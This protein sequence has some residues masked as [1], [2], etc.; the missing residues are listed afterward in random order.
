[1]SRSLC[2]AVFT[3]AESRVRA[4]VGGVGP[5]SELRGAGQAPPIRAGPKAG[6]GL[7]LAAGGSLPAPRL[8]LGE[9]LL[10]PMFPAAPRPPGAWPLHTW[11]GCLSVYSFTSEVRRWL[12]AFR[13]LCSSGLVAAGAATPT[14][15][16]SLVLLS[17]RPSCALHGPAT[18]KQAPGVGGDDHLHSASARPPGTERS[19]RGWPWPVR[20]SFRGPSRDR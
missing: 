10:C 13:P 5:G 1:M 15:V 12:L 3:A 9:P 19:R 14:P 17:P 11:S 2:A 4:A 7:R 16:P 20:A 6:P 18:P 8:R